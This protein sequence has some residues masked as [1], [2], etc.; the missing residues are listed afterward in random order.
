[1]SQASEV[2]NLDKYRSYIQRRRVGFDD[3]VND[4]AA[5][6]KSDKSPLNEIDGMSLL[7]DSKVSEG[8][9]SYSHE[10]NEKNPYT[11]TYKPYSQESN[12]TRQSNYP[13][14]KDLSIYQRKRPVSYGASNRAAIEENRTALLAIK[15]IKQ[16]LACFA[17]LGII[18]FLQQRA[19]TADALL[20]IKSQVVDNHTDVGGIISGVE[21]IIIQ[22]S[23]IFGGSS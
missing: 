15:I 2:N 3:S 17:I 21:N 4:F 12:Y 8:F 18:V 20:F 10:I 1:M 7:K 5:E 6:S 22:C 13:R 19:D 23:K 9:F 11:G 14:R 16:A